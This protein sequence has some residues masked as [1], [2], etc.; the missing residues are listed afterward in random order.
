[1]SDDQTK[2]PAAPD[3]KALGNQIADLTRQ[4]E[5]ANSLATQLQ[6]DLGSKDTEIEGLK[7]ANNQMHTQVS[8]LQADLSTRQ[9]ELSTS[10]GNVQNLTQQIDGLQGQVDTLTGANTELAQTNNIWTAVSETPALHGMVGQMADLSKIIDPKATPEQIKLALSGMATQTAAQQQQAVADFQAG[11]SPP[12]T[13]PATPGNPDVQ[14]TKEQI[15]AQIQQTNPLTQA[16]QFNNL[17]LMLQQAQAA[18]A[19]SGAGTN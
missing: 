10:M 6:T 16:D 13:P 12:A 2:P 14:M 3:V 17:N 18:E 4:L 19:N 11:G 1:M 7:T 9:Q 5:T 8:T 15:F